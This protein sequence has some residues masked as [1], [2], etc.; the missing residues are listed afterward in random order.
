MLYEINKKDMYAFPT[1]KRWPLFDAGRSAFWIM[2]F[3]WEI[4]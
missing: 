4:F 3:I 1:G 2:T